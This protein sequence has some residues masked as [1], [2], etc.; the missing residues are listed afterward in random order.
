M[1]YRSLL[2][3]I[4]TDLALSRL[5]LAKWRTNLEH[6]GTALLENYTVMYEVVFNTPVCFAMMK[7]CLMT[8][9]V[10]GFEIPVSWLTQSQSLA[11]DAILAEGNYTHAYCQFVKNDSFTNIADTEPEQPW[12]NPRQLYALFI[13]EELSCSLSVVDFMARVDTFHFLLQ[14]LIQTTMHTTPGSRNYMQRLTESLY[15]FQV[16]KTTQHPFAIAKGEFLTLS[17]E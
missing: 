9:T 11:F 2:Y 13:D 12:C 8:H 6:T 14:N 4:F 16:R 7:M 5:V 3:S 1:G 15:A 17:D 10:N